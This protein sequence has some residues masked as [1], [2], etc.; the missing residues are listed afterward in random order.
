MSQQNIDLAREA[1]EAWNAGDMGR[2]RELYDA[3]AV[4]RYV[5]SDW[6]ESGP[7]V[8]RDAIMRQFS[9]LR[10]TWDADSLDIVG[11]PVATGSRVLVH[12]VWR[13]AGRGPAGDMEIA[14]VY[15]LRG[16]LIVS[17]E[18]FQDHAVALEAAGLSE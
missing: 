14:W 7:F 4:M 1:I 12:A 10:E 3:D 17:A 16:G 9:W 8:G 2:I 11:N 18:F 15:T 13:T 6:P 5:V